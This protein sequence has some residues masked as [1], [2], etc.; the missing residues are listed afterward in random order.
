MLDPGLG[1]SGT[2]TQQLRGYLIRPEVRVKTAVLITSWMTNEVLHEE[3]EEEYGKTYSFTNCLF[4]CCN[5]FIYFFAIS[6][7]LQHSMQHLS[8]V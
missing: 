3:E 5:T 1:L 2:N 6:A 7:N 8:R 4:R